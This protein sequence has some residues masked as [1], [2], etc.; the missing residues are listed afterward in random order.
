METKKTEIVEKR[1]VTT[2]VATDGTEFDDQ[3]QCA[4]YEKS[5]LGVLKGRLHNIAINEGSEC[6]IFGGCGSDETKA[7]VVAPK[8]DEQV[9]TIQQIMHHCCYGE[10]KQKNADRIVIGKVFV[11]VFGYEGTDAW[12]IDFTEMVSL[13][14][15]GKFSLAE[16]KE[17]ESK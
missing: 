8:D 6:D 11:V 9:K 17:D 16:V 4:E 2:Y 5:A 3:A 14:T 10:W 12:L 7:Y 1:Y 15:T 13:A